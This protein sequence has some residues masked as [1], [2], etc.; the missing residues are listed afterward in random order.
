MSQRCCSSLMRTHHLEQFSRLSACGYKPSCLC[1]GSFYLA[2]VLYGLVRHL[3]VEST[4]VSVAAVVCAKTY[5]SCGYLRAHC[6]V[7]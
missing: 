1:L 5:G 6:R 3:L 7:L 2:A 4:V